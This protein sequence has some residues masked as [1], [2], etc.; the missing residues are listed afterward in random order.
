MKLEE[1]GTEMWAQVL[2]L[3]LILTDTAQHR[4][5]FAASSQHE[6]QNATLVRQSV[7]AAVRAPNR[8]T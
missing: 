4:I 8:T 7:H 3:R 2:H 5:E 6:G 1:H